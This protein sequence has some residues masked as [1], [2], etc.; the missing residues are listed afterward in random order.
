MF[1]RFPTIRSTE[2]IMN[3]RWVDAGCVS[4]DFEGKQTGITVVIRNDI[5][6]DTLESISV[7]VDEQKFGGRRL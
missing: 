4:F 7:E 6:V 3:R 1:V 2:V 5:R